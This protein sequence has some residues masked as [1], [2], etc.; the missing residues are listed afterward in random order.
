[1]DE[2]QRTCARCHITCATKSSLIRHLRAKTLCPPTFSNLSAEELIYSLH[3][4]YSRSY[5]CGECGCGFTSVFAMKRHHSTAHPTPP[6]APQQTAQAPR[7]E[8]T[9]ASP[10]PL[11]EKTMRLEK[12]FH[13]LQSSYKQ[14]ARVLERQEMQLMHLKSRKKEVFFQKV[15]EQYLGG[16]HFVFGNGVSDITTDKIHAEIKN[17]DCWKE[18]IGQLLYYKDCEPKDELHA[19]FFGQCTDEKK[20]KVVS[21]LVKQGIKVF[22]CVPTETGCDI[23]DLLTG[24]KLHT[25]TAE[26]EATI[27]ARGPST[28]H[29]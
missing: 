3:V 28:D 13:Q 10:S 21:V 9:Q 18:V 24:T 20:Q 15:L 5:T 14:M 22:E 16:T 8:S 29:T 27:T 25:W 4:H 17:W 6:Q 11:V 23:I 2:Q 1:M 7:C 19:Y 12:E 26:E